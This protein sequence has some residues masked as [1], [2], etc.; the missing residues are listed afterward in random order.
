[1]RLLLVLAL[2]T[3]WMPQAFACNPY[4]SENSPYFNPLKFQYQFTASAQGGGITRDEYDEMIARFLAYYGPIVASKGGELVFPDEWDDSMVNGFA[5]RN[6]NKWQVHALGG[7]AR[8]PNSSKDAFAFLLCHEMGH[9]IGGK[10]HYPATSIPWASAEG[11][12]DYYG[13]LKCMKQIFANEDNEAAVA[14]L[15]APVYLHET[16]ERQFANRLDQ[17]LCIRSAMGGWAMTQIWENGKGSFKFDTPS[18]NKVTTTQHW[19]PANQCRIDTYLAAALCDAP[20]H[21]DVDNADVRIG[22][23]NESTQHT[24]GFRPHCWYAE[25]T[26]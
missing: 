18:T 15:N 14:A 11:Q 22:T 21:V 16:C 17:L 13:S 25:A 7:Y 9:H 23:C 24:V 20:T 1:M 8:H 3:G 6:G 10:P 2:A 4:M 12:A 26:P 19:H 5:R